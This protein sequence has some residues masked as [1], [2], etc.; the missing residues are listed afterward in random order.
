MPDPALLLLAVGLFCL[1]FE[2]SSVAALACLFL[3][4]CFH[5][6]PVLAVV[7]LGCAALFLKK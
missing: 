5:P 2:L 6:L 1:V 4:F 3:L 7:L